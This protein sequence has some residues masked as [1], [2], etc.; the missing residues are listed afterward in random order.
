MATEGRSWLARAG[1]LV[2]LASGD[3]EGARRWSGLVE[4]DFWT[5]V[6]AARVHL[7]EMDRPT[8]LVALDSA[9][10]RCV[11]HEVVLALLRARAVGD[12][13]AEAVKYASAAIDLAVSNG[14]LQTVASEGAEVAELVE[15]SVWRAPA[16]WLDRFRRTVAPVGGSRFKTPV[17]LVEP[18]TERELDVVRFLPSRL[19]V[20][21]IA[22]ELYISPN[23]L[24]FHL[25]V[26]YRK[27]DVSSRTQASDVA[28]RMIWGS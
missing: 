23:T 27:L 24:K 15:A 22:S 11:R 10:P 21:E 18:L 9:V 6:S 7:A 8:A 4:D 2:D 19:T 5:G 28:R 1:T 14:M 20:R 25:K 26:I 13:N 3:T 12:H 16:H 17:H